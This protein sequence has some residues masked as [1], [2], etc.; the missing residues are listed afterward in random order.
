MLCRTSFSTVALR[1]PSCV[2]TELGTLIPMTLSADPISRIA[3]RSL[4][5]LPQSMAYCVAENMIMRVSIGAVRDV[6]AFRKGMRSYLRIVCDRHCVAD[7]WRRISAFM[8]MAA[9][10]LFR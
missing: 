2:C 10:V 4:T 5:R 8:C 6:C 7:P 1:S 9:S 3:Y